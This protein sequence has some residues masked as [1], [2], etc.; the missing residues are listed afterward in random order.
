MKNKV[1]FKSIKFRSI[2]RF[3]ILFSVILISGTVSAQ[4]NR[5]YFIVSH[6]TAQ[7]WCGGAAGSGSGINYSFHIVYKKT[8]S[9]KFD[10]VWID[11]AYRSLFTKSMMFS[12]NYSL[13]KGDSIVL[14]AQIYYPGEKDKPNNLIEPVK[15]PCPVKNCKSPVVILF[16]VNG[17][18]YYYD[19]K[20]ITTLEPANYP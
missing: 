11:Y 16:R 14:N 1:S 2:S 5:T 13:K 19:L 20:N 12:S 3:I 18:L 7:S 4:I 9:I 8:A 17:K 15:I 6:A 10:S